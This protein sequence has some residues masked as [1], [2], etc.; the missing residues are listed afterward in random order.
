MGA[1][2][3]LR[4]PR[5]GLRISP[6]ATERQAM[7][8][9]DAELITVFKTST[10]FKIKS[11]KGDPGAGSERNLIKAFQPRGMPAR[12]HKGHSHIKNSTL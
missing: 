10:S 6:V 7:V 2:T 11:Q 5:K 12:C 9:R 8:Q 1:P 4:G 3:S